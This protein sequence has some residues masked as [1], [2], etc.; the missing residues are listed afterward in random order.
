M[1]LKIRI[2][3]LNVRI[4]SLAFSTLQSVPLNNSNYYV[5]GVF[6]CFKCG[7][8]EMKIKDK[9]LENCEKG[10]VSMLDVK[11]SRKICVCL[12]HAF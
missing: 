2:A 5:K 7:F 1:T 3:F 10:K 8:I 11:K 6:L 4:E 9:N 12:F